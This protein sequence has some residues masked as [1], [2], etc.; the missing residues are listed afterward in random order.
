MYLF[1]ASLTWRLI[2]E[3]LIEQ[4]STAPS[5]LFTA[6]ILIFRVY[7]L[8][9]TAILIYSHNHFVVGGGRPPPRCC[10]LDTVLILFGGSWPSLLRMNSWCVMNNSPALGFRAICWLNCFWGPCEVKVFLK[11]GGLITL[12][13]LFVWTRG[14]QVGRLLLCLNVWQQVIH[15]ALLYRIS[16]Q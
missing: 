15:I 12:G 1:E 5:L 13:E 10:T 2:I 11:D 7:G 8:F 6:L 3:T 9:I 16:N 14:S 4:A